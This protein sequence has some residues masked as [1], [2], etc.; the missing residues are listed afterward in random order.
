MDAATAC[1]TALASPDLA[2]DD[3]KRRSSLLQ[4][5]AAHKIAAGNTQGALVDLD[6]AA[7]V[8]PAWLEAAERAR[9]LDISIALLRALALAK[10]DKPM[11]AGRLIVAAADARPWLG[12]LQ[13]LAADM[14]QALPGG[15]GAALPIADR[16]LRID[17]SAR[18]PRA[19]TRQANGDFVGALADWK[20][21][22]PAVTEP[23]T[24]TVPMRGIFVNGV[25][26]W[27]ISFV[28]AARVGAASLAAAFAGEPETARAWLT[29]GRAKAA[30]TPQP[31]GPVLPK[32]MSGPGFPT[33]DKVALDAAFKQQIALVEA[34]ILLQEG[35][36]AEAKAAAIALG[37][38]PADAASIQALARIFGKSVT[39]TAPHIKIDPR[40][41][42]ATLPR[43]EG[44]T[45]SPGIS[46]EGSALGSL[47]G[48]A[49]LK[50]KPVR[51][52][53]SSSIR[54]EIDQIESNGIPKA[55]IF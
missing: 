8:L 50:K 54:P 23:T 45:A 11:E 6:A 32:G 1:I 26:G 16:R 27:P 24:F 25:Q 14:L 40:L 7:A 15:E 35:K 52:S 2:A 44:G 21:V 17:V 18:E 20:L 4:A 37:S 41:I 38:L 42:F 28:D 22:R 30:A 48:G 47:I 5:S 49:L 34:V 36:T 51:N 33:V 53:Y 19:K 13:D 43:Y 10:A 55:V 12:Q 3:W 39:A 46:R 31:V 9:S 29:E